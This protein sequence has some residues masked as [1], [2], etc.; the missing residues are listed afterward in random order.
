[1]ND[2]TPATEETDVPQLSAQDISDLSAMGINAAEYAAGETEKPELTRNL[3]LVWVDLF[4]N[5]ETSDQKIDIDLAQNILARWPQLTYRDLPEYQRIYFRL[6]VMLRDVL[7]EVIKR[8]ESCT[9]YI[10]EEDGKENWSTY[11]D[12]LVQWNLALDRYDE[13]WTPTQKNAAAAV[14]ASLSVRGFVFERG[15]VVA[16]LDLIGFQLSDDEFFEALTAAKE[17]K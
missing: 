4:N 13:V 6:G 14:A 5:F 9:S 8:H 2:Q 1:M 7:L 3:L 10:G 12:L 11:L 16:H 15:G 17:E